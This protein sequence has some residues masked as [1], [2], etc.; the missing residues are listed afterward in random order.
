M[1]LP[2]YRLNNSYTVY[3]N[4]FYLNDCIKASK[5]YASRQKQASHIQK[6][7]QSVLHPQFIPLAESTLLHHKHYGV[8][9]VVSTDENGIM[10]V[11][12][13]SK[14]LHFI[15]PD[16]VRKGFLSVVSK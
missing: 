13:D 14:V 16:A 11:A 4:Y 9:R 1:Y 7:A 5:S 6:T 8:G 2:S 15:Y 10:Q 3:V 12:F